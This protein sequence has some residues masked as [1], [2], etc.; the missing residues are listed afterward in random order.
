MENAIDTYQYK[1]YEV[2]IYSDNDP[3]NPVDEY[4]MLST[5]VCVH[6]R[7][8]LGHKQYNSVENAM[9]ETLTDLDIYNNKAD[10]LARQ[11]VY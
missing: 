9:C 2:K 4:D 11:A 6:S 10:K 1:G 7:Y 3:I 8:R 5:M